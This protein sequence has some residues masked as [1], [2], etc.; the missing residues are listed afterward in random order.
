[1]NKINSKKIS[2]VGLGKLG[3][4]IAGCLASKDFKVLGYDSNEKVT[5]MLNGG[6]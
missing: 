5:L 2:V 3:A 6:K 1:M 4:C